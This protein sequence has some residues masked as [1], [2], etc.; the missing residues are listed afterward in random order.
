MTNSIEQLEKYLNN[1]DGS[2]LEFIIDGLQGFDT[3]INDYGEQE[4]A[5]A[6]KLIHWC[7]SSK[8]PVLSLD[9]PSG[10]NPSSGTNDSDESLV[11]NSRFVASIGLPLSSNLNMYKFGY[12]EKGR[13]THY[14]VDAGIPRRVYTMKGGLRK[15]DRRWFAE[16]G[17]V[18]LKVV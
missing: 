6:N 5:E 15:F 18:E 16:S 10:L 12:C 7:N 1:P 11:V 14:L 3:D 4:S 13:V 9:I 8:V 2:P 17:S